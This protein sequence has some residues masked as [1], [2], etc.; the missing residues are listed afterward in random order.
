M[1]ALDIVTKLISVDSLVNF[2]QLDLRR[3][4][5]NLVSA[6][7]FQGYARLSWTDCSVMAFTRSS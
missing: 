6:V 5:T 1:Q 7:F 3:G 2:D 4:G